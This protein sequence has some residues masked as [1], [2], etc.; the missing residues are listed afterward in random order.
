MPSWIPQLD[1]HRLVM[2]EAQ[3][4]GAG[5]SGVAEM[6]AKISAVRR[7]CVSGTPIGAGGVSDVYGMLKVLQYKPWEDVKLFR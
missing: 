4:V 5:L 7:W 2:D 3:M 6:A 1:W